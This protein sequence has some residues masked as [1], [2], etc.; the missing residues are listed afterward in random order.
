MTYPTRAAHNEADIKA[1]HR[2][3]ADHHA[4]LA[5]AIQQDAEGGIDTNNSQIHSN[6]DRQAGPI[7]IDLQFVDTDRMTIDFDTPR[8]L[9]PN[10]SPSRHP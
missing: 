7:S 2:A 6:H 5:P 4:A 8:I 3:A 9:K 10:I 1:F